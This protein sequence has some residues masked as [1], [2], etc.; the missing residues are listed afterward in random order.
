LVGVHSDA[1][2]VTDV[3][4]P[5]HTEGARADIAEISNA[6]FRRH[7]SGAVVACLPSPPT[8]SQ[9]PMTGGGFAPESLTR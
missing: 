2:A 3:F 1:I 8:P 7:D 6:S 5:G 9:T 4:S